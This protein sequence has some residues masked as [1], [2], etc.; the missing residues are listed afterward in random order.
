MK[1][2]F[3]FTVIELIIVIAILTIIIAIIIPQIKNSID[4][5][6]KTNQL[7]VVN[8]KDIADFTVISEPVT[9]IELITTS[10]VTPIEKVELIDVIDITEPEISSKT[11]AVSGI[12]IA[13]TPVNYNNNS[14]IKI[15]EYW[16]YIKKF[17]NNKL[18]SVFDSSPPVWIKIDL[19]VFN[20]Q[21]IGQIYEV[22]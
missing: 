20:N 13:K 22:K 4:H 5:N 12:I 21:E 17:D 18:G 8:N 14:N 9:P 3:G 6:K 11:V 7:N 2:N 19:E 15:E 16:F 10:E 1:K